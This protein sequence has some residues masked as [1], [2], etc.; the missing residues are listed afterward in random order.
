[1]WIWRGRRKAANPRDNRPSATPATPIDIK[2]H[3]SL[4]LPA[5]V[6]RPRQVG[7]LTSGRDARLVLVSAPAGF[8]KSALV[9]EWRVTAA[10]TRPFAGVILEPAHNDPVLLWTAI[11][12]SL[13]KVIAELDGKRLIRTLSAQR[14]NIEDLLL[15]RLLNA[16]AA[17]HDP[18]ILVLDD[19]HLLAEPACHRQLET[20]VDRLPPAVQL[21]LT[22]RSD[23]MLPLDRYRASGD[24]LE[25]RTDEL[26]FDRQEV[27]LLVRG[28][29]GIRLRDADLDDL[30]ER[31]EGWPIAIYLAALSLRESADPVAF[32]RAFP[33]ANGL[34]MDY[35]RQEVL[36]PLPGKV[37][38]FLLRTSIL[39]RFT[40][41]LCDAVAGTEDATVMLDQLER[42]NLFVIPLD[43][44][45]EWYR[46]HHLFGAALRAELTRLEPD[47]VLM[48][49]WRASN[50][51]GEHE[52]I[53]EAI[54]HALSGGD[55]EH[56]TVLFTHHWTGNMDAGLLATVRRWMD[57]FGAARI[58]AEPIGAICAAGVMGLSGHR[59]EM[60]H[61]LEIAESVADERAFPPRC[62][63]VRFMAVLVR[64]FFGFDGLPEMLRAA[65][66]A[67]ALAPETMSGWHPLAYVSL[68]YSRYLTG[69]FEAAIPPLE[70]AAQ[71]RSALPTVR[72][73]ALSVLSLIMSDLGRTPEAAELARA[74]YELVEHDGLVESPTT[75]LAATALG[76]VRTH[77]G[78]YEE[79]RRLLEH[80]L[81]IRR[82]IAG[83][84]AWPTLNSLIALANLSLETGDHSTAR[85][86]LDEAADLV[87]AEPESS[88]HIDSV[89]TKIEGF[90][91]EE[92][93]ANT[94]TQ[95]LTE[96]LTSREVAVLR[97]LRGNLS[98]REIGRELYVSANTVKTHTR[99]IYRKLGASSREEAIARARENGI[100]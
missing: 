73:L 21:V 64:A 47:I 53:N 80:S 51:C 97:L 39:D 26:R 14:P 61:W 7:L 84:S 81:A 100:L 45:H 67:V 74:A 31:T 3:I 76:A 38:R 62:S 66:S 12:S 94:S 57:S 16:L 17:R 41:P 2:N 42:S 78:R 85:R 65:E 95:V 87:A 56:A 50:W 69:D 5:W 52:M 36:R 23:P 28:V 77:E 49:H 86:L 32:I 24:I 37:R 18:V 96:S 22:T 8:G 30:V 9:A 19:F 4:P 13:D 72:I 20:F 46:Y 71:N 93:P 43:N 92:A 54:I 35:L 27:A 83:L 44:A 1:M 79:A 29:A 91:A 99:A 90:L 6:S 33:G 59:E 58:G 25:L 11:V 98:L 40:A 68:G 15:P 88:A 48:L 34:L 89:L 63:S 70:E 60:R 55:F 75:T 82:P 10:E